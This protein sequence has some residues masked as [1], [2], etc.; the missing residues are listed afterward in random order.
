MPSFGRTS[1]ERLRTCHPSLQKVFKEVVKYFD[2]AIICGHRTEE[3]QDN[4]FYN[5]KSTVQFPNSK[6]N[7]IPSMAVD[8]VPWPIDWKDRRRM[9]YFAGFVKGIASGMGYEIRFGGDWDS[10]TQ[11][12]DNYFQ[13]LPHYELKE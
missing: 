4:V 10:D 9:Y 6:H 7:S 13:D 5:G 3:E 8:V 1:T 12:N 2:C 11:V